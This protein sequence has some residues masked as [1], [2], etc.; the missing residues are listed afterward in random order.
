V[1][2]LGGGVAIERL[3]PGLR[4]VHVVELEQ[5]VV[6]ANRLI[7]HMRN[8]DPLTDPRVTVIINDARN[9]LRL[10]GR[11]Y[12]VI[13]SQPS[14]PWTAGASHLFTAEFARLVKSRLNADGVFV[15]WTSVG[16]LDE[17]TLRSLT[18]TLTGVFRHVRLYNPQSVEL[19]FVASDA[20]LDVERTLAGAAGVPDL[21]AHLASVGIAGREDLLSTLV[22]D[23]VAA[24]NFA[25]G[26]RPGTDDLNL[27][28]TRSRYLADGLSMR[29][30]YDITSDID[31]LARPDF[32]RAVGTE[33]P[34]VDF[35]HLAAKLAS[36]TDTVARLPGLLGATLGRPG[37]ELVE[38]IVLL[39][40]GNGQRAQQRLR[41]IL[42]REPQDAVARWL[43]VAMQIDD[44]ADG[45][46]P[47]QLLDEAAA[48]G[49]VPAAVLAALRHEQTGAWAEVA[50][51]D[52]QLAGA[53]SNEPWF[54]QA[55]RLQAAWRLQPEHAGRQD[56]A[57]EALALIDRILPLHT[58][59][60]LLVQR[61]TAAERLGNAPVALESAALT[62]ELLTDVSTRPPR[63]RLR[64]TLQALNGLLQPHPEWRVEPR[65]GTVFKALD[66]ANRQFL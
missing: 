18:A 24:V 53:R 19:L 59:L 20:P 23:D 28:A 13:V 64:E 22:L 11:R 33:A 63:A 65:G 45:S 35:V 50:A 5:K 54:L 49:G 57:A 58:D 56:L 12:D 14:H 32:W 21:A 44:V 37:T 46:A 3:P 48:L 17:A 43:L 9:A 6:T 29:E 62:L 34:G 60:P 41:A 36:R 7:G 30:L 4:E 31:P 38:A 55:L 40:S 2:G 47:R 10:T 8:H 42:T 66:R 16:F 39:A 52:E 51:L 26:T 25:A 61:A 15:Q 27:M 1:I